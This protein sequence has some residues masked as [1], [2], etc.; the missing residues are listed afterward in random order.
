MTTQEQSAAAG[1]EENKPVQERIRLYLG[2]GNGKS[3]ATFGVLLRALS[4]G[5]NVSLVFFD[6]LEGN[7][8]EGKALKI[9]SNVKE[10]GFGK[11]TVHYT[12]VNRIG[13]GP[14]G[15]FRLYSS[16]NGI[17][18]E[19]KEAALEGLNY[20]SEALKRKDDIVIGDEV[21]D[22]ARVGLVSWD[23]FKAAIEYRTDPTVLL[24]TGRRAPDWLME[25]ATT[26]SS[27]TQLKHHGRA[28]QGM[29]C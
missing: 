22:V 15:S 24:L 4:T 9:L 2:T 7:S 11:L 3:T 25:Q 26:I 13:T 12:G 14:K 28:I 21:L 8:S 1:T 23:D 19:D 16:P 29:D 18:P 20:I 10:D 5:K 6:K 27:T 17:L